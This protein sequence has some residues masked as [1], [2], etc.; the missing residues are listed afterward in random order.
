MLSTY[1][2]WAPWPFQDTYMGEVSD[3]FAPKLIA[4]EGTAAPAAHAFFDRS[5]VAI[6]KKKN[7]V[8]IL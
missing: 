6:F 1:L 7:L 2:L 5:G 4:S 8:R 3:M